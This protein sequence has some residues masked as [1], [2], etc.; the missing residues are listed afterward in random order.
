MLQTTGDDESDDGRRVTWVGG[1]SSLY[2][3]PGG[4]LCD[5]AWQLQLLA[6]APPLAPH[7]VTSASVAASA[8]RRET[9]N[10]PQ[11]PR[12]SAS[13]ETAR[14]IHVTKVV[15]RNLIRFLPTTFGNNLDPEG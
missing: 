9:S 10:K 11:S 8:N 15:V 14:G 1:F 7:T 5:M 6:Q 3:P 12:A 4:T 13:T 2:I